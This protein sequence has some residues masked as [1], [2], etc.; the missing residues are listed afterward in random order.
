MRLARAAEDLSCRRARDNGPSQCLSTDRAACL[1]TGRASDSLPLRGSERTSRWRGAG[2]LRPPSP[3]SRP[4]RSLRRLVLVNR[5]NAAAGWASMCCVGRAMPA[6]SQCSVSGRHPRVTTHQW[7][8]AH[9]PWVATGVCVDAELHLTLESPPQNPFAGP[10]L[11]A[12]TD[13][14]V[15]FFV[16]KAVRAIMCPHPQSTMGIDRDTREFAF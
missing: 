8:A 6:S 16:T 2:V 12:A 4:N 11:P 14:A 1:G 15:D 10:P 7:L 9:K 5:L 3:E 13:N